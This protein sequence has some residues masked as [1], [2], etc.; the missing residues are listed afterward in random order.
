MS[1]P[2]PYVLYVNTQNKVNIALTIFSLFNDDCTQNYTLFICKI[3]GKT[4]RGNQQQ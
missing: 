2:G 1:R 4:I 3:T